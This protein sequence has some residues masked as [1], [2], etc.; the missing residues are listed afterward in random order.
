MVF[1]GPA[2]PFSLSKEAY[3]RRQ[4]GEGR[5]YE[6]RRK[7]KVKCQIC[8]K[9]MTS[10]SLQRHMKN[11]H[12]KLPEQY[13]YTRKGTE[14]TFNIDIAKGA[15]NNCPIPGCTGTSKDKFGMYRHFCWCH[16]EAKIIIKD[17]G[18]V[19]RCNLCGM[20]L[21]NVERHQKTK[22]CEIGR[23][24]RK[25]E[26]LQNEQARADSV[27]FTVYGEKLERV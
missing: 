27:E 3:D 15:N 1:R 4:T 11:Q 2:A 17:D 8:G 26:K 25:H 13:L 10:G 7:A 6:E 5:S 19:E 9:E 16:P 18:E 14:R 21:K 20:F 24:R 22:E 12:N 23:R